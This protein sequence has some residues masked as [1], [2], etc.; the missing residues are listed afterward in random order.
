MKH[1]SFPWPPLKTSLLKTIFEKKLIKKNIRLP[2]VPNPKL[3]KNVYLDKTC[4][5]IL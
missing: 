4:Y 1:I 2:L 5:E 3:S